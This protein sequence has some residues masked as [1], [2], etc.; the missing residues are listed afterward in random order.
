VSSAEQNLADNIADNSA[1]DGA[2]INITAVSSAD[3]GADNIADNSA[4][5]GVFQT[6]VFENRSIALRSLSKANALI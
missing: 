4:H 3:N 6:R 5:D 2:E 1:H